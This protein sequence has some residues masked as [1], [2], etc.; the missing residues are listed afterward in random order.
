LEV[1]TLLLS[2]EGAHHK[3]LGVLLETVQILLFQQYLLLVEVRVV[4]LVVLLHLQEQVV[5]QVV[6]VHQLEQVRVVLELLDKDILEDREHLQLTGEGA[7]AVL[8]Q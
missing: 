1:L 4:A 5:D 8:A 2:G 3:Q 7:G 6:V